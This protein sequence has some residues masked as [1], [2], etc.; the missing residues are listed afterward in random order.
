[1][2]RYQSITRLR[3]QNQFVGT[4]GDVYYKTVYYPEYQPTENDIYVET[5]FGDRLDLLSYQFYGD[6]SLY[7]II[8]ISNPDLVNFGSLYLSPG[9]QLAI[10]RDIS[11]IIDSYNK[12]NE[13]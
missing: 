12:L 3:N 4:L 11:G 2:N 9:T 6:V 10:P 13:L 1:M 8:A 5:E 7:W